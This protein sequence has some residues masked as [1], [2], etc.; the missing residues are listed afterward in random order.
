MTTNPHSLSALGQGCRVADVSLAAPQTASLGLRAY[1]LMRDD[2]A[3]NRPLITVSAA[4]PLYCDFAEHARTCGPGRRGERK[5]NHLLVARGTIS[6]PHFGYMSLWRDFTTASL[7]EPSF[8]E[9]RHVVRTVLRKR[10]AVAEHPRQ[11]KDR[12]S[13]RKN[14]VKP[15]PHGVVPG[16]RQTRTVPGWSGGGVGLSRFFLRPY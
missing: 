6:G 15:I 5:I 12:I 1:G 16:S 4:V 11:L 3:P 8:T 7:V 13:E 2:S 10:S 9:K 14:L